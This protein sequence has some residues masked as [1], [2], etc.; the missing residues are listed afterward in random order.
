MVAV[1]LIK[2]VWFNVV[3]PKTSILGEAVV[4]C[5]NLI[6]PPLGCR[7]KIWFYPTFC[8]IVCNVELVVNVVDLPIIDIG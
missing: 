1:L 3:I 7:S 2:V 5:D 8:W 6:L 4:F